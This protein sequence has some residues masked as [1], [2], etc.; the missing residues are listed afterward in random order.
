MAPIKA[1]FKYTRIKN[2]L[3]DYIEYD[4]PYRYSDKVMV[5][6]HE[7]GAFN[8]LWSYVVAELAK[9]FRII[10][11]DIMGFQMVQ[12]IE[13]KEDSNN[14]HSTSTVPTIQNKKKNSDKDAHSNINRDSILSDLRISGIITPNFVNAF[15]DF[16][17]FL[18]VK[19]IILVGSSFGEYLATAFATRHHGR[20]QK[21]IL[22]SAPVDSSA[23]VIADY[24]ATAMYPSQTNM[25][26]MLSDTVFNYEKI[27]EDEFIRDLVIKEFIDRL[28][29]LT[30]RHA[31]VYVAR[32][33]E[34]MH[35]YCNER[36]SQISSPTII[37][38]GEKDK[39]APCKYTFKAIRAIPSNVQSQFV[40]I[41]NCGH[42][43]Q[44]EK[45]SV[46]AECILRFVF[47]EKR[48]SIA[49]FL[50]NDIADYH[51]TWDDSA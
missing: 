12:E 40:V 47:G 13:E 36:F 48:L 35:S 39:M 4:S 1:S 26:K 27:I 45:P 50:S 15:C 38:D 51:V 25:L 42:L 9:Y 6:L 32:I 3:I 23:L 37:I 20:V 16:L 7:T 8:K 17:N 49:K 19:K 11:P 29:L 22:M 34:A 5:I 41:K 44:L 30:V 18:H 28:N 33:V 14:D 24:I 21:L 10:I 46:L 2:E 43:P 31:I